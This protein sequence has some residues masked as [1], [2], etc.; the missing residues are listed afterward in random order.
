M[1]RFLACYGFVRLVLNGTLFDDRRR[2][3]LFLWSEVDLHIDFP[4]FL[5]LLFHK[6]P[7]FLIVGE[8]YLL[9]LSDDAGNEHRLLLSFGHHSVNLFDATESH[10]E[11]DTAD[12]FFGD[13]L[14][15]W[16]TALVQEYWIDVC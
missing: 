6:Q 11:I 15:D 8:H 14:L 4:Y 7:E 16:L 13:E 3:R 10:A 12:C 2:L 9:L 5:L 1:Q